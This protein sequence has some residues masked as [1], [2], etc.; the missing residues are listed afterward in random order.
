MPSKRVEKIGTNRHM[1]H[2]IKTLAPTA[3]CV[4]GIAGQAG[5]QTL[6]HSTNWNAGSFGSTSTGAAGTTTGA[7]DGW[8]DVAGGV[9][10][11]GSSDVLSFLGS[12]S[13]YSAGQYLLRPTTDNVLNGTVVAVLPS[14]GRG[15]F[16]YWAVHR[17]V[18][19]NT[20]YLAGNIP[21]TSTTKPNTL[22][23]FRVVS[24][25][26]T[27]IGTLHTITG[28]ASVSDTIT[29]TSTVAGTTATTLTISAVDT[30]TSK[31]LGT[32]TITESATPSALQVA[33]QTGIAAFTTTST[34]LFINSAAI[35]AN[36]T[37]AT[38]FTLS[39]PSTGAAAAASA[40]TVTPNAA[41]SASKTVALSDSG[42]DGTFSPTGLSFASN[43]TTGQTFTYTP[44]I[45]S[46]GTSVTLTATPSP[47]L[48]TPPTA[49]Y[50][51]TAPLPYTKVTTTSPAFGQNIVVLVPDSRSKTPY[52]SNAGATLI[53]YFHGAGETETG[54]L[55]DSLKATT[56]TAAINAGYIMATSAADGSENWG[57]Q[58]S[59]DDYWDLYHYV[60][61]NYKINHVLFW[62]QS[63]GGL[64]SLLALS[65]NKIPG[66]CGWLGTYPVC[67]LADLY[68][69]GEFT[70]AINTAYGITGSGSATYE[71]LTYGNDP[72]LKW[73]SAFRSVPMRFYSSYSD[74]V[75]PRAQNTD[76][77]AALVASSCREST[78]VTTTG[79]HGDP[80][81]FQT[82]D[83][84]A[85]WAR[86][87]ANVAPTSVTIDNAA[88][89]G[90]AL[91]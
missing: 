34:P 37:T 32:Y 44:A 74:T 48:G 52:N 65:Q 47:T 12:S 62:G 51:V 84:L 64:D 54:L 67:S 1:K 85:F 59:V 89:R 23:F 77:L 35:Y 20:E 61:S 9:A 27:Q 87:I 49:P 57:N 68:S 36:P 14:Q 7:G 19:S 26:L 82:S 60:A 55:S 70:S 24:G 29:V 43:A 91:K 39:G 40:F 56:V 8:I 53:I 5:A 13:F 46:S 17:Y 58:A 25:V 72:A 31:T 42:A 76:I 10:K 75:V 90:R 50:A 6:I 45:G 81:N 18:G 63:M 11:A 78:V 16:A 38:A 30:T 83:Y 69:L 80:S 86:C 28:P 33:G 3:L 2:T 4:L 88:V 66:V 21:A 73:G 15:Y 71:N 41:L 22:Q 79:N